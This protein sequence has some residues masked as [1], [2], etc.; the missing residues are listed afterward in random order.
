LIAGEIDMPARMQRF[1]RRGVIAALVA[2]VLCFGTSHGAPAQTDPLPS[3]NDGAAKK[4]VTDF[5]TRVTVQ[6]GPD[7]V[8]LDQR[9]S[10]FDNDGTLWSEQPIY[11]QVAFAIDRV[12]AL[13]PQHPDWKQKEPFKSV[14]A[15]DRAALAKFGE[16]GMLQI[17]AA[18]HTGMTVAASRPSSCRAA[19]S[20]SC[21]RGP[22]RSTAS[23]PSRW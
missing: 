17:I 22:R 23:R 15:G 11:F 4:S 6:G 19:A 1:S 8:P 12:K 10:T 3:W 16:K 2:A 18:T 14:L 9:I 20:S 5:V 13:A 7:F 21:G